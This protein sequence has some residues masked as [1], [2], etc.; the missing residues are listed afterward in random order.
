MGRR[1]NG[2]GSISKRKDG[3]FVG[4][5]WVELPSGE[6]KRR[7][8]Y[9]KDRKEVA[10]ALAV[11]LGD[12]TRGIVADDE[13]LK[14]GEYLDSW[15]NAAVKGSVATST[16]ESYTMLVEKHIK[17]AFGTIRLSMLTPSRLQGF[18]RA[19]LDEGYAR[20]TVQYLHVVIHRTLKQAL[21]WGWSFATSPI[22]STRL[23]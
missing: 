14:F 12:R 16:F 23:A 2:E 7:Y 13:Q 15:L 20:R 17:P 19:K 9:G 11:A 6:K 18:Y 1:G 4:R 8:I 22:A 3:R 5:Y 10:D 21:R